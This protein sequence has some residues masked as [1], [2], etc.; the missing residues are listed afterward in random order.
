MIIIH[1]L[2]SEETE[3]TSLFNKLKNSF[4]L[5]KTSIIKALFFAIS[6]FIVYHKLYYF[7]IIIIIFLLLLLFVIILS[8]LSIKN[9]I[10]D[11]KEK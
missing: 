10:F 9:V 11:K 3:K 5:N 1:E 8:L 7:L 2:S 6:I 4:L